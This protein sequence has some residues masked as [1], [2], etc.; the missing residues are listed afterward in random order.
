MS[1]CT[2]YHDEV[3]ARASWPPTCRFFTY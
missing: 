2:T 3:R 1:C